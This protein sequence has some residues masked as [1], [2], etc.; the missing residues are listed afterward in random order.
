MNIDNFTPV[1][2][3]IDAIGIIFDADCNLQCGRQR[4]R[5]LQTAAPTL[6]VDR[7]LIEPLNGSIFADLTYKWI[8]ELIGHWRQEFIG[9]CASQLR[10]IAHRSRQAATFLRSAMIRRCT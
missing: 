10:W 3:Q 7:E 5:P 2:I 6:I 1:S 4:R 8:L 9:H